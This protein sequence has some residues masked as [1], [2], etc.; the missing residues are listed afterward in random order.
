[1]PTLTLHPDR[2]PR[3]TFRGGRRYF[4]NIAARAERV[5][6][7]P[8]ADSW[9]DHWHYHADWHGWGN[10]SWRLRL[11]HLRVLCMVLRKIHA[12]DPACCADQCFVAQESGSV[13]SLDG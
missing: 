13:Q 11:G 3:G 1:M 4:R 7:E 10:L 9:W 6:I 2:A 12:A 8:L 5:T